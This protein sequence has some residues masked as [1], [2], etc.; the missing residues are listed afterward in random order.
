MA[1]PVVHFEV[2]GDDG[3]ALQRF[4]G[5]VF[6]WEIDAGNPMGYGMVQ[7]GPIGGGI[8]GGAEGG[9]GWVTWYVEVANLESTLAEVER[10]GGRSVMPPMDVPGGPRM[11]QFTDP[12]GHRIGLVQ[13]GTMRSGSGQ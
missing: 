10:R 12:E 2:T 3:P 6:G 4:Y 7:P 11:A 8:S 1:N 13:A 9:G 5:D